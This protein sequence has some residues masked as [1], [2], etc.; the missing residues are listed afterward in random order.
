MSRF[1]AIPA[2][3]I[4]GGRCVRL[5]QG[6]FLQETAYAEDPVEM[7]LEWQRQGAERVHVVDLDGARDGVRQN[8][9]V[10]RRLLRAVDVPVQVGGGIR[11]VEVAREVLDDG[12][13]RVVIGTA[14]LEQADVLRT[15]IDAIGAGRIIVGVDARDGYVATHGWQTTSTVDVLTFCQTLKDR[16]VER[17]LYTDVQRDGMLGGPNIEMTGRIAQVLGVIGSG[18]VSTVAHL[19]QLADAG[20]EAAIIGTALYDGRLSLQEALTC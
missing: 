15:C 2:V 11:S 3:D 1:Q 5:R 9:D 19:R 16:G 10:I 12:A 8:A 7:A 18:G 6:D 20:A 4:R 17:V 14:A 13:A